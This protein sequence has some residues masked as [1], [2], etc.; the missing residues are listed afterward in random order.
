MSQEKVNPGLP[1]T[2]DR[3]DNASEGLRVLAR[4]I[5]RRLVARKSDVDGPHPHPGLPAGVEDM[6]A[7]LQ[8]SGRANK[9]QAVTPFGFSRLDILDALTKEKGSNA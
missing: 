4:M 8:S 6:K 2:D 5:A 7:G 1:L 3:V 9:K